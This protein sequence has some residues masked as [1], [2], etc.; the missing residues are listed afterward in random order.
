MVNDCHAEVL[1][2]RSFLRYLY[3]EALAWQSQ[4]ED[5]HVDNQSLFERHQV[6]RRLTL[7]PQH[8]LHLFISEA[9]CGDAAIYELRDDV[10]DELVRQRTARTAENEAALDRSA[11]RL[12]GAKSHGKRSRSSDGDQRSPPE[13]R[14]AQAVGIARVKAG[15]SDLPFSK[16]TLS[17]SCSDKLAKWNAL[18]LQGSLLLQWFEP[19]FLRSIVI[20]EDKHAASVAKQEEAL[21]RA[22]SKRLVERS[23]LVSTDS[24]DR[25]DAVVASNT[26]CFSRQRSSKASPSSLAVN[27]TSRELFWPRDPPTSP[28][29]SKFVAKF[30][31]SFEFEFLMAATGFKQGAKKASKMDAR[32]MEKV[33]SRL[34]KRN[35]LRAFQR[36]LAAQQDRQHVLDTAKD[37]DY[38][39]LKRAVPLHPAEGLASAGGSS[40]RQQFFAAFTD[41][42]GAPDEFK[43]FKLW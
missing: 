13:K 30:F 19:L 32:A 33:A 15:R 27:W 10:V 34:A 35:L 29:E 43:Q 12:T 9:P 24:L 37:L 17:M 22:V 21:Q 14:F 16:Q 1:A 42:V 23:A 26:L 18:G 4:G 3:A 25:F 7:K 36:V 28:S 11:L 31:N 41:W 6:T 39:R 20:S 8:S 5:K 40:R 2:R 38:L